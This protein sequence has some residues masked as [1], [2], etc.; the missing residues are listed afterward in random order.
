M[1]EQVKPGDRF[2]VCAQF[3]KGYVGISAVAKV[4]KNGNFILEGDKQQYRLSN[5]GDRAWST[6]SSHYLSR[7]LVRVTPENE[8]EITRAMERQRV[9]QEC[10][11]IGDKLGLADKIDD[12]VLDKIAP[13]LKQLSDI[14]DGHSDA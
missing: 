7:T 1:N 8:A 14:L 9:R 3:G 4:Y 5:L 12:A 11:R 10:R 13:I 6:G 2:A